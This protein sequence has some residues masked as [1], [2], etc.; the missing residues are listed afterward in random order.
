MKTLLTIANWYFDGPG[1]IIA[2]FTGILIVRAA[3]TKPLIWWPVFVVANIII[4]FVFIVIRQANR[5]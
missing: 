4:P 5:C 2:I 1:W 3:Q